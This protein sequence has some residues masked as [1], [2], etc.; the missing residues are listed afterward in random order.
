M[1]YVRFVN[2]TSENPDKQRA[3]IEFIKRRGKVIRGSIFKMIRVKP[4]IIR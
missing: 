2:I 1:I 3:A 4:N